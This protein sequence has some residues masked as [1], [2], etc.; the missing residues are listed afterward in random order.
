MTTVSIP[1][2]DADLARL[3]DE[4]G[5]AA[6]AFRRAA[7]YVLRKNADLYSRLA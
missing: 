5:R 2:S 3:R 7:D 4:A 1:L 6:E